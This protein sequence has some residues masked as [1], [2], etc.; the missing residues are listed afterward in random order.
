MIVIFILRNSIDLIDCRFQ[1]NRDAVHPL[2]NL[3]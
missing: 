1:K 2:V 3:K